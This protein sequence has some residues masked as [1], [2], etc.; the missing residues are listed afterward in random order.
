MSEWRF[1]GLQFQILWSAYGSDRL[2]YPLRYRPVADSFEDL[3][4]Q[5]E[6]AVAQL[7]DGF[8]SV[9]L[10][11]VLEVLREPE[12]RVEIKG[13]GEKGSGRTYRFHGAVNGYSGAA[14]VQLE[15]TAADIGGDVIVTACAADE[16]PARALAALPQAQAGTAPP[17]EV[18]RA[19]LDAARHLRGHGGGPT[20]QLDRVFKRT[21]RSFGEIMVFPGPAVDARPAFGRSFWWMDYDDGRYYVKTGDPIVA[22]PA[23]PAALSNEIG[24]LISITQRFYRED[25]EHDEYLRSRR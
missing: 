4:M 15:G 3:R 22:K 2:P 7:L 8:Y 20:Q 16:V 10:M 23:S 1:T 12:A 5:R 18:R 24:R 14:L 6:A 21:R 13:F 9:E 11:R 19:E 25:R 17:V